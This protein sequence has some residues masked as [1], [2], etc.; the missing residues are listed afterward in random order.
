MLQVELPAHLRQQ[1]VSHDKDEGAGVQQVDG[2]VV[3]C[4]GRVVIDP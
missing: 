2:K 4:V 1:Q 3:V